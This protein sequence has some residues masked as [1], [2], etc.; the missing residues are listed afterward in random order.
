[1]YFFYYLYKIVKKYPNIFIRK[2]KTFL[3]FRPNN[4]ILKSIITVIWKP[5]Y[6][7]QR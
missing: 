2:N 4:Y 1:M 6:A 5:L 7:Y 3:Y